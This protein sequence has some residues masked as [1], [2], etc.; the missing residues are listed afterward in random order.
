MI[1][2]M[3]KKRRTKK[4]INDKDERKIQFGSDANM[5]NIQHYSRFTTDT[6]THTRLLLKV[7]DV[8]PMVT[9]CPKEI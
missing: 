3:R 9:R 8:L 4:L 6:V 2:R 5:R 1:Q 7:F